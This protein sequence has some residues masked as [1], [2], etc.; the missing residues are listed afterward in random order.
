MKPNVPNG[1]AKAA[2]KKRTRKSVLSTRPV[3]QKKKTEDDDFFN[4][5]SMEDFNS[6]LDKGKIVK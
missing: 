5:M 2:R 3:A 4:S 6:I 1:K